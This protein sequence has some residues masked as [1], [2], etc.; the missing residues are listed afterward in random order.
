MLDAQ[1]TLAADERALAASQATLSA[2]QIDLFL[3]LGGGWQDT[4]AQAT[5]QNAENPISD[6]D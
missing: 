4:A 2:N 5:E 6:K 1:R 3:A